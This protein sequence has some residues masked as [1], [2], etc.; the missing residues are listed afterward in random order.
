MDALETPVRHLSDVIHWIDRTGFTAA[1]HQPLAQAPLLVAISSPGPSRLAMVAKP[2]RALLWRRFAVEPDADEPDPPA[3]LTLIDGAPTSAALTRPAETPYAVIGQVS[4]PS[5]R[6]NPRAFA[7]TAGNLTGHALALYRTP[8]ATRFPAAGGLIAHLAWG[9]TSPARWAV[10]SLTVTP[11]V[12]GALTFTAQADGQG[13]LLL[14]FGRLPAL[15]RDAPSSTYP[16]TLSILADPSLGPDAIPDPDELAA[17]E[18]LDPA[19]GSQVAAAAIA[20][21]PGS[22]QTITSQGADHLALRAP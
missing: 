17:A 16:A 3:L 7:I 22:I 11:P 9:D 20:V 1:E 15:T 12:G 5:G 6:F 14:P 21:G 18:L 13:D 19:D 2:G 8:D 10:A 4:D